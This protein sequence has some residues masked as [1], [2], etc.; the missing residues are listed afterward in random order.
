MSDIVG[1]PQHGQLLD[2]AQHGSEKLKLGASFAV[3]SI[4]IIWA[5]SILVPVLLVMATLFKYTNAWM[6]VIPGAM[7]AVTFAVILALGCFAA[8]LPSTYVGRWREK[9]VEKLE[10][11]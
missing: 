7:G 10:R 5:A 3:F 9:A 11:R 1:S 2:T 6:A 8:L 4:E